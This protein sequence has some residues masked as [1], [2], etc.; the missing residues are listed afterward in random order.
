MPNE[1]GGAAPTSNDN[2]RQRQLD[3]GK[4][5]LTL[6]PAAHVAGAGGEG[7]VVTGVDSSGVAAD[8]GFAT[9]DVILEVAGKIGFDARRRA[10]G[11]RQRAF[12]RQAHRADAGE[13][14]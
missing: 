7:V 5:G 13:E 9:G 10:Q 4:L 1:Q 8:H 11:D 12:G 6:A 3:L 14:G 2:D